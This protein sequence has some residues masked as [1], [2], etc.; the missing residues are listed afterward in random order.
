MNERNVKKKTKFKD[1]N[2]KK[3][4]GSIKMVN[5]CVDD[6]T[7]LHQANALIFD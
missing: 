1:V 4:N 2:M 7:S 5:V 3:I 6:K